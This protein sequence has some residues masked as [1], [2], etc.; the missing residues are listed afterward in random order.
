MRNG[1]HEPVLWA[2]D[3]TTVITDVCCRQILNVQTTHI[4]LHIPDLSL[5]ANALL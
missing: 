3:A 5:T 2:A 1:R 4:G